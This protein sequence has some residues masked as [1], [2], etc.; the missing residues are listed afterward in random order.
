MRELATLFLDAIGP[1]LVRVIKVSIS[2][3]QYRTC[4]HVM[5]AVLD[6]EG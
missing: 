1:V 3:R 6:V 5:L 4:V 2:C